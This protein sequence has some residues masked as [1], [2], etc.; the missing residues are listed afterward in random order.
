M[1]RWRQRCARQGGD[2]GR[3]LE[4]GGD[5]GPKRIDIGWRMSRLTP[6]SGLSFAW[7]LGP[8]TEIVDNFVGKHGGT[9]GKPRKIKALNKLPKE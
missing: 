1:K 4:C 3:A 2:A 5:Y 6:K 9:P 8:S 7:A